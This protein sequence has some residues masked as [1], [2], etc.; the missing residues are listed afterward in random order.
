MPQTV[1]KPCDPAT[2]QHGQLR[3]LVVIVAA[4]MLSA[5]GLIALVKWLP[6]S[7]SSNNVNPHGPETVPTLQQ[8]A[9]VVRYPVCLNCG[10]VSAIHTVRIERD[11]SALLNSSTN[12]Q[13][14]HMTYS[15]AST[16]ADGANAPINHGS[17]ENVVEVV[18]VYR[19]TVRM[20]DG[21][22]RTLSSA[23]VPSVGVGDKV[24][25]AK[26]SLVSERI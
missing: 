7:N 17:L 4:L 15:V 22:Y 18:T 3:W 21:S 25:V 2:L 23:N 8:P 10:T 13:D 24:R 1:L 26:G 11:A 20:D 6:L 16:V 5:S 9:P 12:G 14:R 19:V